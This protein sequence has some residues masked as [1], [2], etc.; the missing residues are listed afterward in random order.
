LPSRKVT[1]SLVGSYPA[2]SPLPNNKLLGGL[3]SVA[4]SVSFA[5]FKKALLPSRYEACC[6]VGVRT[7]LS[8]FIKN[9]PIACFPLDKKIQ[10]T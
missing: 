4:L 9:T 6:F 7:F 8:N 5:F 2:L 3:L 1:S 10:R